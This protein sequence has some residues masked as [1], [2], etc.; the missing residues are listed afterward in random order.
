MELSSAS[1][2]TLGKYQIRGVLGRGAMGTVYDGWDPVIG[3]RVA[4]KTVRL[5]GDADPEVQEGLERFK[6]EAQAAGRLT[7]PNIVGVYDYGETDET[8]YIVMEFVEGPSLKDLLDARE[9]FPIEETA[10][11]MDQV[12]AGLQFSHEH[13]VVHRDIKPGNVMIAKGGRVKLADF[14]I[15]RIESSVMTQDGTMLGT[16]AYMSP[17]QLMAQ[18]V[19]ARSDIYSAGVVLY[20]LLTGER[21]FEGGL[22]AIIH[23]ALNTVPPRPSEIAV[24]APPSL[25]AVV[26]RAMSKRPADRYPNADS[27]AEALRSALA[28]PAAGEP[29]PAPVQDDDATF[30]A[31][32]AG[33]PPPAPAPALAPSPAPIPAPVPVQAAAP[34]APAPP[35]APPLQPAGGSNKA[36]LGGIAAVV[37]IGLGVGG[38]LAMRPS[39]PPAAVPQSASQEAPPVASASP[40]APVAAP[41]SAETAR[42]GPPAV[43][44]ITPQAAPPAPQPTAEAETKPTGTPTGTPTATAAPTPPPAAAPPSPPKPAPSPAPIAQAPQPPASVAQTQAAPTPAP[45][46]PASTPQASTP[47][48]A[49]AAQ[50]PVGK[51]SPPTELAGIVPPNPAAV[52]DALAA[53][54]LSANCAVPRFSMGEDGGV[55]ALGVVGAGAPNAA[56][57]AAVEKAAGS[58]QLSWL[59]VPVDGPYCEAFNVVR[60]IAMATSPA[61]GLMMKD[62]ITRLKDND[63]IRP[64]LKLPDFPAYLQVDYLSHDG[65]VLHLLSSQGGK[66]K[67]YPPGTS[68]ALGDPKLGVG[69]VGP[70]FGTDV[71][72][73]VAS[74][75]PLFAKPRPSDTESAQDYLP[76]LQAAIDTAR[77]H[78][79]KL[80]GRVLVLE[81]VPR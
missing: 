12:L 41:R 57:R 52:R 80:S 22:T 50:T 44:A 20:Q 65:S 27:F 43:S 67:A 51:P 8:A 23:K 81:T 1:P 15:A 24:T 4:I 26:A 77:Q 59:V 79:A 14:G 39:A 21:P 13:G 38:W 78:D 19:D 28:D 49:P 9:R 45:T 60:P 25:D 5:L 70:P 62:D 17:E 29:L 7:H 37:V 61:F 75:I 10:R 35:V 54:A 69:A 16:P 2:A 66:A 48:P 40:P 47:P 30:I 46:P 56:L 11:I 36:L 32:P 3:R 42:P 64:V 68:L 74:S 76:A 55:S 34:P 31:R 53:L 58:A 18:T 71:I 73:A 6:R 63:P 72:L 33:A